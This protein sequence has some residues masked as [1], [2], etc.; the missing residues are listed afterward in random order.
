MDLHFLLTIS[1]YYNMNK[2]YFFPFINIAH[3]SKTNNLD[4][5]L[6]FKSEITKF[7]LFW[8]YSICA[9]EATD[10]HRFH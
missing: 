1:K 9:A 8:I 5:I 2:K 3:E 4:D 6:K 7:M 10:H